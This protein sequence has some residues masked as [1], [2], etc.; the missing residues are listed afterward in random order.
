MN[1]HLTTAVLRKKFGRG[2]TALREILVTHPSWPYH[3][4]MTGEVKN[5]HDRARSRPGRWNIHK[6]LGRSYGQIWVL[7]RW[8]PALSHLEA[9]SLSSWYPWLVVWMEHQFYVPRNIGFL[10]IPT[11][12]HIFLYWV[13]NH[14]NWRTPS[15]FRGLAKNH[16]PDPDISWWL[17]RHDIENSGFHWNHDTMLRLFRSIFPCHHDRS[18]PLQRSHPYLTISQDCTQDSSNLHEIHN[19]SNSGWA[20]TNSWFSCLQ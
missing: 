4:T 18:L 1:I 6:T 3:D 14:P 2:I 20:E 7:V 19:R 13:A 9:M 11:D 10:I 17:T 5:P 8:D 12:F 16:Q 15:F